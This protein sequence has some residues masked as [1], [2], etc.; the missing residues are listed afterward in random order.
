YDGYL[1]DVSR[2]AASELIGALEVLPANGD[3]GANATHLIT[4]E[5]QAHGNAI[6]S[7]S[8]DRIGYRGDLL[9]TLSED[10]KGP[11]LTVSVPPL[12]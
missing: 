12:D 11:Q 9:A 2:D 5:E 7:L 8:L 3:E 4:S 10:A 6:A 1:L